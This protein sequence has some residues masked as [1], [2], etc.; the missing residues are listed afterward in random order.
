M[1]LDYRSCFNVVHSSYFMAS[2]PRW[3]PI[4]L[5]ASARTA[6]IHASIAR[7]VADHDC[8]AIRAARRVIGGS[9][10]GEARLACGGGRSHGRGRVGGGTRKLRGQVSRRRHFRAVGGPNARVFPWVGGFG[11]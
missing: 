2:P 6:T 10:T 11:Q 9:D 7:P 4:L 5:R 8:A 3:P 1:S